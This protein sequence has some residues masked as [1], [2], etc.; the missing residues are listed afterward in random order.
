MSVAAKKSVI[1]YNISEPATKAMAASV[2]L[3]FRKDSKGNICSSYGGYA[4]Y[5]DRDAELAVNPGDSFF[6]SLKDKTIESGCYFA[7]PLKKVDAEFFLEQCVDNRME[8]LESVLLRG[9]KVSDEMIDILTKCSPEINEKLTHG[10]GLMCANQDLQSNVQMYKSK[11]DNAN[12]TIRKKDAEI[13]KLKAQLSKKSPEKPDSGASKKLAEAKE[14]AEA[15]MKE[16]TSLKANLESMT[17]ERNELENAIAE[18]A[19]YK[20]GL[21]QDIARVSEEVSQ[22]DAEIRRLSAELKA[23]DGEKDR[24]IEALS[25]QIAEL[26]KAASRPEER[27]SPYETVFRPKITIRRDAKGSI[28]SDWFTEPRYKVLMTG[29]L[30]RMRIIPCEDGDVECKGFTLRLPRLEEIDPFVGQAYL[31]A[32]FDPDMSAVE[33]SL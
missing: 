23:G 33:V 25:A 4:V 2:P 21:A 28:S 11:L 29:D 19:S 7:I 12:T 22:K 16:N 32:E 8:F 14:K 6:V 24:L 26:R 13:D 1:D 18:M 9:G 10:E 3:T 31:P 15:V 20:Q 30:T 27:L 5:V 17:A